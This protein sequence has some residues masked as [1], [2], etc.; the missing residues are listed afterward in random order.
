MIFISALID[1]GEEKL[2]KDLFDSMLAG[3]KKKILNILKKF[4]GE[5]ILNILEE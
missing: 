3:W 4:G 1:Q 5:R 2:I